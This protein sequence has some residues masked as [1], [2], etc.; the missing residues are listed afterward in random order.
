MALMKFA[1][2]DPPYFGRGK[3][4]YGHLHPEAHVWDE[5]QSHL[6]LQDK[7]MEE[8]P[9]G[10][11]MSCNPKDLHW[12]IKYPEVTRICV[13]A[14]TFA[15]IRGVGVQYFWEPVL[16]YKGRSIKNRRPMAKDWMSCAANQRRSL[17]GSKP[18]AFNDWI[19]TLL[20]YQVGDELVDLFVGSNS[21]AEAV[22][23]FNA[24]QT[25]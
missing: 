4:D 10:S 7:L 13:W 19:L 3:L 17:K 11:A 25:I 6:D 23:R 16:L 15:Q 9:D 1:Y 14:K 21:M 12:I 18:D 5:K 22:A 2:A 8:F 20:G 24:A